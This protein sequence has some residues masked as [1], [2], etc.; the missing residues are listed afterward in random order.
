MF[1]SNGELVE[2]QYLIGCDGI[3]S[4]VRNVIMK[5]WGREDVVPYHC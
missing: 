3:G 4:R 2:A 5:D 1:L